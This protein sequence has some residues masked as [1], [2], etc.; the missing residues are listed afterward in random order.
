MNSSLEQHKV[1]LR[2]HQEENAILKDMLANRGIAFQAE[3]ET[4]KAAVASNVRENSFGSGTV[5]QQPGFYGSTTPT[6]SSASGYSPQPPI[7]DR[8]YNAGRMGS[9]SGGSGTSSTQHSYSPA[10]PGVF[11]QGII[12]RESMGVPEMAGGIFEADP[13]LQVEFILA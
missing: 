4:R 3:L 2:E 7:P 1:A 13:H 9:V 12:K 5:M 6:P 10:D 8:S 11:E